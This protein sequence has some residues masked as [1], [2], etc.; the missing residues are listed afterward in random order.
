MESFR[1]QVRL[2]WEAFFKEEKQLRG[3]LD[4]HEDVRA[5]KR[6]STLLQ[7]YIGECR[8]CLRKVGSDRYEWCLTP[9]GDTLLY[10]CY[11]YLME[12]APNTLH[13]V[14]DFHDALPKR[15]V[16]DGW[17]N[18]GVRDQKDCAGKETICADGFTDMEVAQEER[19]LIYPRIS[20]QRFDIDVVCDA[21]NNYKKA[22]KT[23][24]MQ[25]ILDQRIG[26]YA[27]MFMIGDMK[28]LKQPREEGMTLAQ[29]AQFSEDIAWEKKRA[30]QH[31]IYSAYVVLPR[32]YEYFLR[33]DVYSGV[34]SQLEIIYDF[35]HK[36][37]GRVRKA[38][39]LGVVVGF[40]FYEHSHIAQEKRL[41]VREN[42][43]EAVSRICVKGGIA[44][45][46]GAANGLFYTY[47]DYVVY[48]W[49]LF[50]EKAMSLF[51]DVDTHMYGFQPMIMGELPIHLVD[52]RP[53]GMS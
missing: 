26:E 5:K 3:W 51:E 6:L 20:R 24:R 32:Y 48:D 9:Q 45:N 7:E 30:Y 28:F 37:E 16:S 49:D 1:K 46:I 23:K 10:L 14:W 4:H 35:I 18:L 19:I 29:F 38:R 42:L 44:E 47:L 31:Q 41:L 17:D 12:R 52:N 11:R 25:E 2:F 13:K 36:K 43:E 33:S 22:D 53:K 34:S 40:L 21:W 15:N 50:V 8:F 39:A 27:R